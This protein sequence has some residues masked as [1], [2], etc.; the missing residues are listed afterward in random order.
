MTISWAPLNVL[1]FIKS[2]NPHSIS[3][4]LNPD[5][6]TPKPMLL[7]IT[8]PISNSTDDNFIHVGGK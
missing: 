5:N 1:Y 2:S 3:T 7:T 4:R 8:H 6:L